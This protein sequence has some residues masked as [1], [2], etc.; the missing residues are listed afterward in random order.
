MSTV[1]QFP[2][3]TSEPLLIGESAAM[4]LLRATIEQ[5]A[6]SDS[7][8][9]VTG[10]SGV[11]KDVVSRYLHF[12]S[13][14]RDRPFVAVNCAA[15][16]DALLESE[17]FGHVRGSF[18]G[19][20]RDKIGKLQ[21]A[22]TGAILLDEVGEMSLRMQA[23]LLRFLENG[24]LQP[25]GSDRSGQR[26]D[27][28][29]IA[30][31]NRE[32]RDLI[33]SGRF[34]EDLM[35][36]LKVVHLLVPPL[37]ERRDDIRPLVRHTLQRIDRQVVFSEE[38]LRVLETYRWPGNVR[39]LQNVVEQLAWTVGASVIETEHLP[40]LLRAHGPG[41]VTP[42]RERRKQVADELYNAL[43]SRTYS[44]W[45]HVHPLFL[46]RD[47]TRL[48]IRQLV[49]LGLTTTGGNYR[50]VLK[51]FGMAEQDYKRFLNFLAAHDC[52]VDFR[53]F[54]SGRAMRGTDDSDESSSSGDAAP[55]SEAGSCS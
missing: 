2:G 49:R 20:I 30:A 6:R 34:R 27:V 29:V 52:T 24:E 12:R 25:V 40:P 45:E 54:R 35:Y 22:H 38:A 36:R 18:T 4:Q 3:G 21:L 43:V 15:F 10:E 13:P 28:R 41:L 26:V 11:G 33:A 46:A 9:L 47:I 32:L 51:L 42:K 53:P 14:R 31:T 44:F 23:M 55:P 5:V 50:A 19:A 48:D 16:S 39:E 37:R 1:H 17:L 8:V 7:K